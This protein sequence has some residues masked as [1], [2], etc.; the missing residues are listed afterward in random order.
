M[1]NSL[2]IQ[3][4]LSDEMWGEAVLT[5]NYLLNK[6]PHKK[7]DK[8]PYELWK[9]RKPS[10]KYLKVWGCLAKVVV[11]PPKRV[12]L[13]PK[14]IDCVFLGYAENS[15]AYRF[16]VFKSDNEDIEV[17]TIMESRNATFFENI[18]PF[19]RDISIKRS[20]SWDEPNDSQGAKRTRADDPVTDLDLAP[21]EIQTEE[22]RRSTRTKKGKNLWTRLCNHVHGGK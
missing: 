10:Y 11:P 6:L 2:L 14:T 19:G 13:G 1:L 17:D 9:G 21:S 8:T 20:F 4:G 7:L 16:K 12:K 5:A 22:V 15:S 18:F 3:S